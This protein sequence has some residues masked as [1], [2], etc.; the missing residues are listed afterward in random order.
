[1]TTNIINKWTADCIGQAFRCKDTINNSKFKI[2]KF[3]IVLI[4]RN[5][6]KS[7]TPNHLTGQVSKPDG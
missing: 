4:V 3:K 7:K 2:T 6:E 5:K 1:M